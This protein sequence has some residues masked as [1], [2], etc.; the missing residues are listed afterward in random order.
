MSVARSVVRSHSGEIT[1]ANRAAGGLG[2]TSY[3]RDKE[4]RSKRESGQ[5]PCHTLTAGNAYMNKR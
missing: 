1:L 4:R 2:K 5:G 3:C